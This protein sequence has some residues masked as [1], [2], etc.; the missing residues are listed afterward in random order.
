MSLS[1]CATTQPGIANG[2]AL[3]TVH[4]EQGIYQV[5][6]QVVLKVGQ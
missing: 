6:G 4:E 2:K 1:R 3:Y 5:M